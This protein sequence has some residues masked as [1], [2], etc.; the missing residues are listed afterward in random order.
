[1]K[2]TND[3]VV[4]PD[5]LLPEER[6]ALDGLF[7]SDAT[8]A[9]A[10]REWQQVRSALRCHYESCL[11]DRNLFVAYALREGGYSEA[12][13]DGEARILEQA[14]PA[15]AQLIREHP[16]L[17]DAVRRIQADA[18]AFEQCWEEGCVDAHPRRGRVDRSAIASRRRIRA[19]WPWR[20]A[21]GVAF[22][23]FLAVIVSVLLRDSGLQTLRTS[24]GETRV[25][26]L[27]DGSTVRLMEDS[28]LKY[29]SIGGSLAA[30]RRV[31]LEGRAYFEVTPGQQPFTV[32]TST[33][34]ATVLGTKFGVDAAPGVT[35][36]ILTTGH[37]TLAPKSSPTRM[38]SL[39]PGQMS[40]VAEGALPTTPSQVNVTRELAWTG[41]FIFAS[42]PLREITSSLSEAYG[43][44]V[45]SV[46]ALQGEQVTGTFERDRPLQ[47]TLT[48]VAATLGARVEGDARLG[49]RLVPVI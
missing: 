12:L 20:A 24:P 34:V 9:A 8:L 14:A 2:V 39:Q 44:P 18:R 6:K 22:L 7:E 42:T 26:E 23:A 21:V 48:A 47:E 15:I 45:T 46:D 35:E 5:L 43:V 28:E 33:A 30:G 11:P 31:M 17:G 38:V 25:V 13:S 3:A 37:V 1:M 4:F 16:G 41:L 49:Y 36:V 32:E 10:D 40:R 19:R 29:G 27:T